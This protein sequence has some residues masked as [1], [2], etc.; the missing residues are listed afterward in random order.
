M[1]HKEND[2][3]LISDLDEE[4]MYL[5]SFIAIF[6]KIEFNKVSLY[7]NLKLKFKKLKSCDK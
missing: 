5:L 4:M 1:I 3:I 7:L 2:R 6:Q